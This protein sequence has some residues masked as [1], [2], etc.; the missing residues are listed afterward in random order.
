MSGGLERELGGVL[1]MAERLAESA[2]W[3][4]LLRVRVTLVLDELVTNL[5]K[6]GCPGGLSE[7]VVA[8]VLG[9]GGVEIVV[10]DNGPSFD[11]LVEAP[12]VHTGLGVMDRP[13]GGLGIHLVKETVEEFRYERSGGWNRVFLLVPSS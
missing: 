13:V 5:F 7:A 1:E 10:E 11:P 6:H 12:V 3:S 9:R 4:D 8:V 2:G